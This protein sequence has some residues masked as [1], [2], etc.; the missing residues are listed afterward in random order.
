MKKVF[1]LFF[2][3]LAVLMLT[4]LAACDTNKPDPEPEKDPTTY[5]QFLKAEVNDPIL[6]DTYIQAR[7]GWWQDDKGVGKAS[8]YTQ[9]DEGG[10]FI[11]DMPCSKE[12]YDTKLVVGTH[13]RVAGKK[14]EWAGE[15]EVIEATFSILSGTKLFDAVD[16]TDKLGTDEL[17][18]YMNKK[19]AF[20]GLQVVGKGDE[21]LPF[22]Y[23]W[24]NAGS[25]GDD[26]YFDLSDGENTYTFTVESYLC[27]KDTPT[28][29]R[30]ESLKV[31]DYV[32]LE[33]FLYWYEGAQ[34]HVSHISIL[35]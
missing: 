26:I 28:Y 18:Q 25:Q 33:G 15:L 9:N 1:V 21:G 31:G 29:Q 34:P 5:E 14:G 3:L 35:K 6:I 12:E 17:I 32:D 4:T 8:F 13:I 19:V 27:G 23:K 22:F 11:Y 10:Y 7:Q 16:V 2:T 20:K 30:V 24:N